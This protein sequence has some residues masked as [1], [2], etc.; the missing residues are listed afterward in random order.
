M[1]PSVFVQQFLRAVFT[2]WLVTTVV[3]FVGRFAS[4]PLQKLLPEDAG[5]EIQAQMR[6]ELGLD[7][8]PL[9]QYLPTSAGSSGA[10]SAPATTR[11][12]R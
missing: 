10:I 5:P 8:P 2:I 12:G 11:A 6:Q 7:R 4:D 9:E 3:F 1:K